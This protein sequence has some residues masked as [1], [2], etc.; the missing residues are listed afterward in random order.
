MHTFG[1]RAAAIWV[2]PNLWNTRT[3]ASAIV[4][5]L[6]YLPY[7]GTILNLSTAAS[8]CIYVTE[9]NTMM[10]YAIVIKTFLTLFIAVHK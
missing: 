8:I 3:R 9:F 6:T 2:N 1:C 10:R 5:Q 7:I 4:V